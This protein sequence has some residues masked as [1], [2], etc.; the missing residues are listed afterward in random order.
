MFIIVVISSSL[1]EP[2]QEATDRARLKATLLLF[3][4]GRLGVEKTGVRLPGV[5]LI[6]GGSLCYC[7]IVNSSSEV[8]SGS[9]R[10]F[11]K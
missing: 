6:A 1:G 7:I 10:S 8:G 4:H 2:E 3:G 11:R 5:E 9:L